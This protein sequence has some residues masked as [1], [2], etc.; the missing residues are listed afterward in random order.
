MK[1]FEGQL[2]FEDRM[3]EVRMAWHEAYPTPMGDSMV[4]SSFILETFEDGIVVEYFDQGDE[5]MGHFYHIDFTR[6]EG[7]KVQFSGR[8]DWHPVEKSEDWVVK[9]KAL[10]EERQTEIK[11]NQERISFDVDAPC[12]QKAVKILDDADRRIGAYATVWGELDC[13]NERMTKSAIQPYVGIE[14]A[15]MM[16]WMHGIDPEFGS[17]IPGAWV[18]STFKVDEVGLYVEGSIYHNPIGDKAWSRLQSSGQLGL[19][20]GTVWYLVKRKKGTDGTVD[21][22]DWPL[23]EI[24]IMEGGKQCVPSAQRDMKAD[25]VG[26]LANLAVKMGVSVET[27]AKVDYAFIAAAVAAGIVQHIMSNKEQ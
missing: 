6:D 3:H 20:L 18:P 25:L 16:L 26:M 13:D 17:Q 2:S 11:L 14:A 22:I 8:A 15:P 4:G 23:L 5:M 10:H 21:I 27:E 24:S 1:S 19:S 9:L 7:G 12:P